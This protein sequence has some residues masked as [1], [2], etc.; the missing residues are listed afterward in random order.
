[1]LKIVYN[2]QLR[3]RGLQIMLVSLLTNTVQITANKR[4]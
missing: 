3:K 2:F 1:M 4:G